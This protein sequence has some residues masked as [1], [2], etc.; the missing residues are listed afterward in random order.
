MT[1]NHVHAL[2][3]ARHNYIIESVNNGFSYDLYLSFMIQRIKPK[4]YSL[5][6]VSEQEYNVYLNLAVTE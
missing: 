4:Y 2:D 3:A 6:I 1:T 5:M